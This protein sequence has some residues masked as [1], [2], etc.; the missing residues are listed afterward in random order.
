[1]DERLERIEFGSSLLPVTEFGNAIGAQV[2]AY[3]NARMSRDAGN[4][5][6]ALASG[7]KFM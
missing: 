2:F 7:A 6:D 3:G 5:P 1:V 4:L